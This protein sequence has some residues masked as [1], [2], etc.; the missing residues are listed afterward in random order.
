MKLKDCRLATGGDL[1]HSDLPGITV[2]FAKEFII[3]DGEILVGATS[4]DKRFVKL[5]DRKLIKYLA[6]LDPAIGLQ[7]I[8]LKTE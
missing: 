5:M 3:L 8:E 2:K 1:Y 4:S 7:L 6:Y